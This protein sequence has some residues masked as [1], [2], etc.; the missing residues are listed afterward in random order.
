MK[1][2]L[3]TLF[4]RCSNCKKRIHGT[5]GAGFDDEAGAMGCLKSFPPKPMKAKAVYTHS[6]PSKSGYTASGKK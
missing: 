6:N 1:G 3:L 2:T 4:H 5:F